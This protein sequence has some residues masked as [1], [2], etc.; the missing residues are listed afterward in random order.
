M[1]NQSTL[2]A[3]IFVTAGLVLAVVG[4]VLLV[5]SMGGGD[6]YAIQ[7]SNL[8]GLKVGAAV[9]FEGY[10]IGTVDTIEPMFTED[11]L[12]FEVSLLVEKGWPIYADSVATI[13]SE[14]LLA[15]KAVQIS[16][17]SDST[18]KVVGSNIVVTEPVDALSG[19]LKTA[20]QF[21]TLIQ[22]EFVPVLRTVNSLLDGEVRN[23][24][25]GATNV[26]EP[27]AA[28]APQLLA[29]LTSTVERMELML[30]NETVN[31]F[32]ESAEDLGEILEE[33]R[34]LVTSIRGEFEGQIQPK[35][36]SVLTNVE[37]MTSTE[38]IGKAEQSME[39]VRQAAQ[40]ANSLATRFDDLSDRS[41]D[42]IL[43]I[44]DRLERAAMNL[45]DM[46]STLRQEPSRLI[47][48]S[49]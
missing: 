27:L 47:R 45:E 35:V 43:A 24:V 23:S 41:D 28:E 11:G 17:G 6:R 37:H 33:T 32:H 34:L 44:I 31:T 16:R 40:K 29:R 42:R 8:S 14:N 3:G 4:Y 1:E 15:P 26:L 38:I 49:D 25:R 20:S 18:V 7:L 2:K 5:G 46:T 39:E 22:D 9:E 19:V 13:S 12:T 21:E 36:A 48:G 30:S 10:S